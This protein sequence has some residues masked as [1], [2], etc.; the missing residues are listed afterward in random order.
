MQAHGYAFVPVVNMLLAGVCKLGVVYLLTGNPNLGI[1]GAP[2]GSVLGYTAIAA[3]NLLAIGK[4]VPQ[5]PKLL[6]NLLRPLLPAAVMG[7]SV[8]GAH[9]GVIWLFGADCSRIFRCAVPIL[10]GVVVYL[11][12]VVLCKSIT[13]EDCLLLPKGE[14]IAKMLKLG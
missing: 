13:K 2:I 6:P 9:Q 7:I 3:M 10:V 11:L 12:M 5:K 1:L 4:L 14:K 8:Y